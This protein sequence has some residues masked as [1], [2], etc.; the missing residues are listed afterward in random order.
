MGRICVQ[1]QTDEWDGWHFLED[2][3]DSQ[4][5]ILFEQQPT[6]VQQ[7]LS[8]E[9]LEDNKLVI[10][11]D[12]VCEKLKSSLFD[13]ARNYNNAWIEKYLFG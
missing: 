5:Y 4:S 1:K 10:H 6:F 11:Q 2:Y 13:I 3:L 9:F 8:F 12:D 7:I